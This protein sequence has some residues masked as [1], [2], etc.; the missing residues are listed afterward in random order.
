VDKRTC[1][2]DFRDFKIFSGSKT[3]DVYLLSRFFLVFFRLLASLVLVESPSEKYFILR[4]FSVL[5]HYQKQKMSMSFFRG[6]RLISSFPNNGAKKMLF[7]SLCF[8]SIKH[9]IKASVN[10]LRNDL[11]IR[12]QRKIKVE[13]VSQLSLSCFLLFLDAN[14]SL[15]SSP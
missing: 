15:N 8:K 9:T 13:S 12:N 5:V 6:K 1:L 7:L 10:D 4:K 11:G 2:S 14:V 3:G